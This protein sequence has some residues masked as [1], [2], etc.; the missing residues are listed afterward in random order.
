MFAFWCSA[1]A[2][3]TITKNDMPLVNDTL[4]V[5]NTA[6]IGTS[7]PT[8][9]D[10]NY[11]WDYSHLT[12]ITQKIDTF[13]S[14]STTPFLYQLYFNNIIMYPTTKADL[15]VKVAT[16]ILTTGLTLSNV[17][18]Y[19]KKP[20][21]SYID[22]GFGAEINSIPTSVRFDS[23]D[24]I[25]QFPMNYGNAD[26]CISKYALNIPSLIYYGQRKKRVNEIDGWGTLTTPFG[27]FQTL[28]IKTTLNVTDTVYI[29]SL[30]FGSKFNRPTEIQYKWLG[31]NSR[32]P[33]L[34]INTI[35]GLITSVV[36]RDSARVNLN[37][38]PNGIPELNT[39][40]NLRIYPSPASSEIS[41]NYSLNKTDN[42]TVELYDVFG[43]KLNTL[44][45]SIQHA[46]THNLIAD[47]NKLSIANGV[48]TVKMQIGDSFSQSQK[49]IIAR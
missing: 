47:V 28:R 27:T 43:N 33:L 22:V 8:L 19:Y 46:G 5:S 6:T 34:Q 1:S 16:P 32:I 7:D 25:Y 45:S 36:Y 49:I 24:Y 10:T 31:T 13:V 23:L 44:F 18:E 42:V 41:I 14:V 40:S 20:T 26:S 37:P 17:F 30:S 21:S 12:Y 3:I 39:M 15:A 11:T 4:R 48:Y 38:L 35:S 9:T 29:N 2:Q